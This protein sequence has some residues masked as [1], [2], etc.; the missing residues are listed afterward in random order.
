MHDQA[1]QDA[2]KSASK[3]KAHASVGER[4]LKQGSGWRW[5]VTVMVDYK[6]AGC[7][8]RRLGNGRDMFGNGREDVAGPSGAGPSGAAAGQGG[9]KS[10]AAKGKGKGKGKKGKK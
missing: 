9:G 8:I 6:E 1:R 10:K 5:H 2:F 4:L 7:T 3:T